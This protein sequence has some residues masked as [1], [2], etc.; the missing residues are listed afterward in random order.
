MKTSFPRYALYAAFFLVAIG[1]GMIGTRLIEHKVAL[2]PGEAGCKRLGTGSQRARCYG[3]VISKDLKGVLASSS[4]TVYQ[5][6]LDSYMNNVDDRAAEDSNLRDV[7]HQAMHVV[8]RASGKSVASKNGT[9]VFPSE[10]GRLCTA[11]Y[12]HGMVEG[13]LQSGGS[14]GNLPELFQ[15]M[16]I[17]KSSVTDCAHGLGHAVMRRLDS[18][19]ESISKCTTLKG[20]A[21][22]DCANGVYMEVA[23]RNKP[24][25]VHNFAGMCK[26]QPTIELQKDC[27]FYLPGLANTKGL[28]LNKTIGICTKYAGIAKADCFESV[29]RLE[30]LDSLKACA[31]VPTQY[32]DDCMQGALRLVL[33][34]RLASPTKARSQCRK[35]L[36]DRMHTNCFALVEKYA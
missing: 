13:Y 25:T 12:G 24:I 30:G 31:A 2:L 6:R 28:S 22:D 9:L 21:I 8:G 14:V 26:E 17:K 27:Y 18:S 23:I 10:S 5:R 35:V 32:G 33:S 7:C 20:I 34:S 16:C 3:G 11:G 29:G 15:H 4:G 19:S 36:P 1:A